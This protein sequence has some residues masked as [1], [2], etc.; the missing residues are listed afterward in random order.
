MGKV[1]DDKTTTILK[2]LAIL[3]VVFYA[4]YYIIAAI[5]AAGFKVHF[6][7]TLPFD[8]QDF[9]FQKGHQLGTDYYTC[10]LVI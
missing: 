7:G 5:L 9:G 3:V 4:I 1:S 2:N 10:K 8:A 6:N